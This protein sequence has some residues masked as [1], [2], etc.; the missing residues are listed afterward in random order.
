SAHAAPSLGEEE[1]VI[2]WTRAA[3]MLAGV[4]PI[5]RNLLRREGERWTLRGDGYANIE[6]F[7][8][9]LSDH[10]Y[11]LSVHAVHQIVPQMR[12]LAGRIDI[13]P[14]TARFGWWR[15]AVFAHTGC[16]G[17]YGALARE[18]ERGFDRQATRASAA[19]GDLIP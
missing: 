15:N 9:H 14:A 1:K 19:V 7:V 6:A 3:A 2:T 11:V 13:D 8:N 16:I 5:E 17:L 4:D 12:R 18:G 10:D